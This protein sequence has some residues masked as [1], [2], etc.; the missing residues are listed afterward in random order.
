VQEFLAKNSTTVVLHLSYFP[1][2]APS[3]FFHFPKFKLA[4]MGRRFDGIIT[5]QKQSQVTLAEFGTCKCFQ[6]W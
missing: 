4:H 6:Q 3:D 2:L 1:D 5:I